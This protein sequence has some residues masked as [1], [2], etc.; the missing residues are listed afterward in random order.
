MSELIMLVL[1]FAAQLEGQT[2]TERNK[3]AAAHLASLGRWAGGIVPYGTIPVRK[4]FSDGNE[5]W[6]LG[7]DVELTWPF[8]L[9]M[10]GLACDPFEPRG[11]A[12]IAAHLEESGAITPKNHRA[13]LAKPP[14]DPAPESRWRDTT[15]RDILKSPA[16]RGYLVREDGSIVRDACG[17]PVMQGEALVDDETWSALQAALG[18]LAAPRSG[19]SRRKDASPLL[20]VIQCGTCEANMYSTWTRDRRQRRDVAD[21]LADALMADPRHAAQRDGRTVRVKPLRLPELSKAAELVMRDSDGVVIEV[22]KM[23]ADQLQ[24]LWNA[25][26]IEGDPREI[27]SQTRREQLRCKGDAHDAGQPAP[28]VPLAETLDFVDLEFRTRFA[29]VRKS[30]EI[31]TGGVDHRPAMAELRE[32]IEALTLQLIK[33]RGAA[34][35]IAARQ[36]AS[37]SD[38]LEELEKAPFVPAQRKTVYLSG[39]WVDDWERA[40]WRGRRSILLAVGARVVV[41]ESTGWRRPVCERLAFEVRGHIDPVQGVPEDVRPQSGL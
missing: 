15:V 23:S 3:G 14:R 36:L 1:A 37:M 13:R 38:R 24:E 30:Q 11:Y 28:F 18:L 25:L 29:G 5:G 9:E 17:Q 6:W 33:L 41:G 32:D 26:G 4:V 27:L 20:G 7:R 40:D 22:D 8:V 34:A 35:D 12:A 19:R 16:L 21:A 31:R 39:T 2:I 10:V